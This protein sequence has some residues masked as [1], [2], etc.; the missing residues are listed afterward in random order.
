M[1]RRVI[2]G[3]PGR[4]IPEI[5]SFVRSRIPPLQPKGL[6]LAFHVA[7]AKSRYGHFN[8]FAFVF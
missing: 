2:T 3:D 8:L 5:V 7:T 4:G 1:G 6:Q